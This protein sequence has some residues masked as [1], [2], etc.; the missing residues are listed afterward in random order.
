[1]AA[2]VEKSRRVALPSATR[3]SSTVSDRIKNIGRHRGIIVFLDITA[4]SG[5]GGLKVIV[6]GYDAFGLAYDLNDGGTPLTAVGRR[7]YVVYPATLDAPAGFVADTAQ[8]PLP[9][10]FDIYVSHGDATNYTYAV[11]YELIP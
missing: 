7:M 10:E 6:R 4:A 3:S 2:P 8:L 11:S 5:T 1:M 9:Q